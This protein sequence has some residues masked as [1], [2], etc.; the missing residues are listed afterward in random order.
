MIV[1]KTDP[2]NGNITTHHGLLADMWK[3]LAKFMK[4]K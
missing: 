1:G 2:S 3:M 4:F